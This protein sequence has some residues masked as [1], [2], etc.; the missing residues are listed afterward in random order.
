MILPT[1]PAKILEACKVN[2]HHNFCVREN[3]RIYYNDAIPDVI[4]VGEHQFVE[5]HVIE[6]WINSMVVFVL[7]YTMLHSQAIINLLQGGN[8]DSPSSQIMFGMGSSSCVFL[9]TFMLESKH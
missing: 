8:L 5:R 7:V 3:K 9:R 1:T 2:Y 6:L 4:Q